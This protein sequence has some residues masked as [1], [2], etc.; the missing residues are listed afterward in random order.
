MTNEQI[1]EVLSKLAGSAGRYGRLY[2]WLQSLDESAREEWC[3]QFRDCADVYG[4]VM[5]LEADMR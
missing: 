3:A 1:I 4:F 2:D 5:R